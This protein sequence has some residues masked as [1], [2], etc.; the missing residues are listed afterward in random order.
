MILT[1]TVLR[2]KEMGESGMRFHTAFGM[3]KDFVF[4]KSEG[5][6]TKDRRR[7]SSGKNQAAQHP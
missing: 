3:I 1:E 6:Q 2:T 4:R 5:A 7:T